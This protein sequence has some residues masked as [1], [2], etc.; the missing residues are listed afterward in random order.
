MANL[1]LVLAQ[2]ADVPAE[3]RDAQFV[4]AAALALPGGAEHVVEG[5]LD[6]S[7]VTAPRGS[8]GF[9]YDPIFVPAGESRT[10]A[11][12]AP[13]EKDA[14]SHR[15][16]AFRALAPTIVDVLSREGDTSPR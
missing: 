1:D 9:G 6:G 5:H 15:G 8:N 10:T 7:L 11:E 13:E 12:L 3:R 4:C 14:I 2:M 16:K